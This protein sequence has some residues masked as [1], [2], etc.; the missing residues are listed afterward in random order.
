MRRRQFITLLGGAA[1][2]PSILW[3][4]GARAQQ[5]AMPVIGFLGGESPDVYAD[6]LRGFR[7]GLSETGY[8]EGRNVSIEYRWGEGRNDRLPALAADLVGRKVNIIVTGGGLAAALAAKAASTTIPIIFQ[9]GSDPVELGLV[10][11]LNRPGRNLTGVNSLNAELGPKQL[12]LLHE[13][14][15]TATN[16][17]FLSNPTNPGNPATSKNLEA[18]ARSLGLQL[19][20]LHASSER[21]FDAV[22]ATL[23][24][25][26][27]GGL[28]IGADPFLQSRTE[29]LAQRALRHAMPAIAQLR[30]FVAAGGAMSYGASIRDQL[31]LVGVYT[32]RILRGEKPADLP[33]QQSTK[34]EL[35]INLKTAKALGLAVPLALQASADELID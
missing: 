33:V 24:Q 35:I 5:P 12:E 10:A 18:A 19:H 8:A 31:R 23:S 26:R 15:P 17:A 14:V 29:Q 13:I 25:L 20:V 34:V 22:F 2:A 3:P 30:D 6:R 7:Q 9:V 32:G 21:D 16:I 27:A 4:L 11:S 1:A 28:L